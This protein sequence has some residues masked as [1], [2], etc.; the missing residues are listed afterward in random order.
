MTLWSPAPPPSQP[1]LRAAVAVL[2][3]VLLLFSG[4]SGTVLALGSGPE[5]TPVSVEFATADDC[6][7]DNRTPR[8]QAS[9]GRRTCIPAPQ[10]STG[11]GSP[12]APGCRLTPPAPEG[13]AATAGHARNDVLRC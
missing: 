12:P 13:P 11:A 5:E 8:V 3:S 6:V 9:P 2:V 7:A 1:V 10:D 4:G